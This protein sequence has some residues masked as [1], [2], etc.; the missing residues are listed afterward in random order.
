MARPGSRARTRQRRVAVAASAAF[1]D[2]RPDWPLLQSALHDRG[3]HAST[4]VW[5]DPAVAWPEFDLVVANGAWDNI[6]RPTE[7]LAWAASVDRH[8]PIVNPP[9]TLRWNMDK[10]YLATLARSGV[11]TV[12]TQWIAPGDLLPTL[13]EGEIVIKPTISGGGYQ[14]ARYRPEE[15]EAARQDIQRLLQADR[16]VMLQPYQSAVDRHGEIGLVFLGGRFSH[17]IGKGPLLQQGAQVQEELW[18]N[19]RIT[20]VEH[21]AP[22]LRTA[23]AALS[24]AEELLGPTTYA[25]VDIVTLA[26][27]MPGVLELE[28][29]DPALF[30]EYSPSAAVRFAEVLEQL[31]S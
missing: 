17:A 13:P 5:T 26:E 24:A 3:L 29:L 28:L 16:T 25:R 31:I 6:H 12:P 20:S 2:L 19:E 8:T 27:G 22:Q 4:E 7:F 9:A 23:Q 18:R 14:T 15:H 11:P 1:P 30:F 10:R 21:S